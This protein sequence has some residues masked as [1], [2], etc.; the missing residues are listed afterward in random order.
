MCGGSLETIPCSKVGHVFRD[1]HPYKWPE[2]GK[3]THGIN[4]ARMA[5]VWMDDYKRLYY[6]HRFDLKT[7]ID[8]K[9]NFANSYLLFW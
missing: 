8:T 9:V 4:T 6:L 3:D 7:N 2:E 1:F 5:E